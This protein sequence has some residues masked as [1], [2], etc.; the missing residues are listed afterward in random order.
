MAS[1]WLRSQTR[2]LP[3]RRAHG[4]GFW[5]KLRDWR[6]WGD[7]H[8]LTQTAEW[9]KRSQ[10]AQCEISQSLLGD[11]SICCS[12]RCSS[13]RGFEI[14]PD[15]RRRLRKTSSQRRT[16]LSGQMCLLEVCGLDLTRLVI[17]VLRGRS[18][19]HEDGGFLSEGNKI[20]K[21]HESSPCAFRIKT[22]LLR[23]TV[24]V[25]YLTCLESISGK[26][27]QAF[28]NRQLGL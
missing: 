5:P 4:T 19:V 10:S 7:H 25:C 26:A 15:F 13:W 6:A 1:P 2:P 14:P 27:L 3:A 8:Q 21:G 16:L 20:I 12:K 24:T 18:P 11:R 23:V 9:W 28:C 22:G 17:L